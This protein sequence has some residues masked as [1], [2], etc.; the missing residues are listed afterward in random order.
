MV[1]VASF[2]QAGSASS[3][4]S[5]MVLENFRL[6]GLGL[7]S[8]R[9]FPALTRRATSSGEQFSGFARSCAARLSLKDRLDAAPGEYKRRIAGV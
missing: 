8:A 6:F 3:A 2:S 9:S 4:I 1:F 7:P 5:S